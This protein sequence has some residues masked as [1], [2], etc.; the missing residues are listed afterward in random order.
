MRFREML[1]LKQEGLA[2][3]PSEDWDQK[4]VSLLEAKEEIGPS[5]LEQV[6]KAPKVPSEAIKNFDEQAALNIISNNTFENCVQPASI[7]YHSTIN[8]LNKMVELYERMPREKDEMMER[9]RQ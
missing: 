9:L 3:E 2:M 7:F 5:L 1:G 4:K 8:S 6:T